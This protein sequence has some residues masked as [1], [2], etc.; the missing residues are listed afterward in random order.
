MIGAGVLLVP[1]S[2]LNIVQQF[3]SKEHDQTIKHF[4]T[5]DFYVIDGQNS[6]HK[7]MENPTMIEKMLDEYW[8]Q[9]PIMLLGV[10][11]PKKMTIQVD[12]DGEE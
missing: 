9:N 1:Y 10:L 2:Y 8:Q 4:Y 12:D 7:F 3:R 6:M 11:K 5:D